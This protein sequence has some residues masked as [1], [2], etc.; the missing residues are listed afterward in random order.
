MPRASL[1]HSARAAVCLTILYACGGDGGAGGDV[2]VP[3]TVATSVSLALPA[4][5]V[6]GS[7]T[8]L[9]EASDDREMAG[10]R[11][12]VDGVDLAAGDTEAPYAQAWNTLSVALLP[13][14]PRGPP[15]TNTV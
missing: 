11:F 2:T 6:A 9:A 3:D 5:A 14:V 13:M 4:G 7:V 10:V 1:K 8:L 12:Q 15:S